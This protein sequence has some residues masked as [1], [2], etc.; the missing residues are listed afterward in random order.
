MGCFVG[1]CGACECMECV[2]SVGVG[3]LSVVFVSIELLCNICTCVC[4]GE[5]V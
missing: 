1:V 5:C 3:V 4:L 2:C